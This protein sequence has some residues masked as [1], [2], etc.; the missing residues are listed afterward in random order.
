LDQQVIAFFTHILP[1]L[2]KS[3]VSFS[4]Y[5]NRSDAKQCALLDQLLNKF[6][7]GLPNNKLYAYNYQLSNIQYLPDIHNKMLIIHLGFEQASDIPI[8]MKML[9][10]PRPDGQQRVIYISHGL[11]LVSELIRTIKEVKISKKKI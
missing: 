9:A 6:K 7:D 1:C 8:L 10:S 2:A 5:F 11:Y 4:L 3:G